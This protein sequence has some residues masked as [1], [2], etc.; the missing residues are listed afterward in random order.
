MT[1][2]ESLSTQKLVLFASRVILNSNEALYPY[3]KW[4][5]EETRRAPMKPGGLTDMLDEFLHHPSFER[6]QQVSDT[7]LGFVGVKEQEVDWPN[8]FLVDSEM[9]WLA[10]EA[11]VDDL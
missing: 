4:L 10:H 9:N 1:N 8:Q 11:P 7:V 5:L 3:H 2:I 6:A